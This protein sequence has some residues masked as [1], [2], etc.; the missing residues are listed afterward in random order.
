MAG[1]NA[2]LP[3][4]HV[5]IEPFSYTMSLIGGKWKMEL[6]YWLWQCGTLRYSDLKRLMKPITHKVLAA[7]LDE[8]EADGLVVRTEYPEMPPRVEY[9]LSGLGLSLAPAMHTL[10]VWG[11]EHYPKDRP[12]YQEVRDNLREER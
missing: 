3:F 5:H 6:L 2:G 9:S 1:D 7:R 11:T 4:D 12:D 8:L 10:C